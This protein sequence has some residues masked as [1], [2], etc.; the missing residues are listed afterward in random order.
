METKFTPGPWHFGYLDRNGQRVIMAGHSGGTEI[1]T[2]WHHC[3]ESIEKEMEQNAK[4][5]SAA[6]DLL[7]AAKRALNYIENTEGELGITLN[8]GDM[9]RASI[10]KATGTEHALK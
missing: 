7:D 3:V 8:S 5:I 9:L 1:A 2:C 4:L 10:A 6:P